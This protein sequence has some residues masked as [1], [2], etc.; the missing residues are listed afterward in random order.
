VSD[1]ASPRAAEFLAQ[2]A[3]AEEINKLRDALRLAREAL[4]ATEWA[5][6]RGYNGDYEPACVRCGSYKND[7][8]G[9]YDWAKVSHKADCEYVKAIKAIAAVL[10]RE[11]E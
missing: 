6:H 8:V 4:S 10:P 7:L 5:G 3:A 2:Q 9:V 1:R 11:G